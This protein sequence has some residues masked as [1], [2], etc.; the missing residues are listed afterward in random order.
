M[1]RL[2]GTMSESYTFDEPASSVGTSSSRYI[3]K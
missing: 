2:T 3:T 1:K